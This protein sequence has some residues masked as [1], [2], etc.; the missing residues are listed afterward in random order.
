MDE[1]FFRPTDLSKYHVGIVLAK[2]V[3][4]QELAWGMIRV[5]VCASL[6]VDGRQ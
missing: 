5:E 4:G 2:N 3:A 1:P 6:L